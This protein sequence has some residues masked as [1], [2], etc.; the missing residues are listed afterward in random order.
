MDRMILEAQQDLQL[1][2]LWYCQNR[3]WSPLTVATE[4]EK[5]CLCG[6]LW[7][8][9]APECVKI[10][11]Q[12]SRSVLVFARVEYLLQMHVCGGEVLI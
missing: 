9:I 5:M 12:T 2:S 8:L 7:E 6:G 3:D 1:L 10:P 11:S 4:R